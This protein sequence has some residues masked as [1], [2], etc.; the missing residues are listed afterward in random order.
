MQWNGPV[1]WSRGYCGRTAH[2]PLLEIPDG[3][4]NGGTRALLTREKVTSAPSI[5]VIGGRLPIFAKSRHCISSKCLIAFSF[6]CPGACNLAVAQPE[7]QYGIAVS[8]NVMVTMRDGVRL[9][10]DI[11]LP[12]RNGQPALGKFPAILERTLYN[13][14]GG[15]PDSSGHIP[16]SPAEYLVPH[17]YAVVLQDV[18]G[19]YRSEGHWQPIKDDPNDGFDTAKWIGSQSWS[20]GKIGTTGT[21]Y[22][23]GTQHAMA[24]ANA[25]FLEAMIPIDAMSNFGR[26]GVRHNGAFELRMFN[27]IFG[28]A[29]AVGTTNGPLAA[30]RA[31]VP[32]ESAKELLE[33]GSHTAEYIRNLPLRPGLTPLRFAPD[34]EAWLVEAMRH[35]DYDD[36]WKDSGASVVDHIAEYKDIPVYHVTGWYDS[37]GSS[38]ANLNYVELKKAKRSQQQLII[39]PWTHGGQA[40]SF[41]G[42]AQFTADAALAVDPWRVR[43]FDHWLRGA[44]NGV[45]RE[46]PVR[47]YVMGGG[48]AHKTTEGRVFVGGHWRNEPDWPLARTRYTRFYIHADGTLS[49]EKPAG[50]GAITYSFDPRNP[51]PTLGG[52]VSSQGTLMTQGATDQR[53]RPGL[54]LCSI[55]GRYLPGTMFSSSKPSRWTRTW[56]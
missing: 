4:Y 42:D 17:G 6:L 8:K 19:R 16:P 26:Y 31:A 49:P 9:A 40:R 48:D 24:L 28:L 32:A 27:W 12:T 13:K 39:G 30:A 41:A 33:L 46:P 2:F 56:K 45:D 53:C 37:W 38:V 1:T 20:N 35:G 11:Y 55:P 3:L 44:D 54:W 50:E 14:D 23:G 47:I 18:R 36:F 21:S 43:W 5:L 25:P 15:V 51:V 7:L 34:Y 29:N 10:T 52:N 22:S